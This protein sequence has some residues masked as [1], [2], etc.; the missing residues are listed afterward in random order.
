MVSSTLKECETVGPPIASRPWKGWNCAKRMAN[1]GHHVTALCDGLGQP[2]AS[3]RSEYSLFFLWNKYYIKNTRSVKSCNLMVELISH[4]NYA[5]TVKSESQ[6]LL[7]S[8][9]AV[10]RSRPHIFLIYQ[11]C[12]CPIVQYLYTITSTGFPWTHP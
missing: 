1:T 2:A 4:P 8:R 10:V 7:K 12:V 9:T 5:N 11:A 6:C 3:S